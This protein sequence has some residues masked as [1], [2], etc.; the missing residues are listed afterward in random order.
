VC[1]RTFTLDAH[2]EGQLLHPGIQEGILHPHPQC[3]RS[4]H[5]GQGE[6]VCGGGGVRG[7]IYTSVNISKF[8]LHLFRKIVTHSTYIMH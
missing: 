2:A 4:W 1:F 8:L 7:V 5:S 6:C 3:G